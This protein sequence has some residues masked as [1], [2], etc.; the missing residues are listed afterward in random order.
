[1]RV[2]CR[3]LPDRY[4]CAGCDAVIWRPTDGSD[5]WG[6]RKFHSTECAN[7]NRETVK[8]PKAWTV[9][10][11]AA[12]QRLWW[13][14]KRAAQTINPSAAADPPAAAPPNPAVPSP[15]GSSA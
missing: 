7:R 1:M 4:Q 14:R 9:A 11:K 8:L 6:R 2:G 12:Y 15:P 13:A 3:R 5:H 10:R